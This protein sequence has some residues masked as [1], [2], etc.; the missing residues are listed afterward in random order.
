MKV[1]NIQRV[2][3]TK[4]SYRGVYTNKIKEALS[5]IDKKH[6][7]VK[8]TDYLDDFHKNIDAIDAWYDTESQKARNAW[9]FSKSKLKRVDERY[10]DKK[11]VWKQ[12]TDI[13]IQAK[14]AHLK[15]LE[16]LKEEPAPH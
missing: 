15:K 5:G 6:S 4:M 1:Q 3:N 8:T 14:E 7:K 11:E 10:R 2:N 13:F 16:P 9:F 12:D